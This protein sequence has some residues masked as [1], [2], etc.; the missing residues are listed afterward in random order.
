MG[1]AK[2]VSSGF[3]GDQK[4]SEAM[5]KLRNLEEMPY[6]V[7][8]SKTVSGKPL[9][10]WAREKRLSEIEIPVGKSEI[11]SLKKLKDYEISSE[12]LLQTVREMVN[13]VRGDF[14]QEEI[15]DLWQ[16]LL[17]ESRS[18]WISCFKAEVGSGTYIRNLADFLGRELW[19]GAVCFKIVRERVGDYSIL[20]L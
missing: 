13:L 18:F 14:R 7:F 20:G 11:F 3:P 19:I 17:K 12:E 5:A 2:L 1:K 8:S 16:G 10:Q 15:L 9:W 4:L 6:P